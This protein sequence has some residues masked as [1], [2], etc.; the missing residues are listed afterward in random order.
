MSRFPSEAV[1]PAAILFVLAALALGCPGGTPDREAPAHAAD[2]LESV[3]AHAESAFREG[4]YGEAETAYEIVLRLVPG[5]DNTTARL[6]TCYIKNRRDRKAEELLAGHLRDRPGDLGSR[7]VMARVLIRQGKLEQ[8][9]DALRIAG[10]AAPDNLVARYN[11]GF[12]A[13]RLRAYEEAERN[14]VRAIAIDP[15]HAEAHYTLGLV[16]MATGRLAPAIDELQ[17]VVSIDPRHVGAHFNLAN[18]CAR[19]G[20]M[21][22]AEAYQASYAELSGRSKQVAEQEARVKSSSVRAVQF[23]IDRNYPAALAE[24]QALVVAHPEHAPLHNKVG[25]L[26]LR[27]GRRDAAL[28]SLRRAVVL[29]PRLSEPHYLLATLYSEMGDQAAA[30]RERDIFTRLESVAGKP[31]Y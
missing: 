14:L 13:Y 2:E 18:A 26:L 5:D 7:L 10:R 6:G 29:D 21:E 16:L 4:D 30:E 23:L 25:H 1:P 28:V 31:A 11:L 17:N 27:L 8:A 15:D 3:R 22:E 9:A 20:R 24:Y 19:A 12:V